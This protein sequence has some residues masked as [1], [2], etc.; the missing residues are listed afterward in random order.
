MHSCVLLTKELL[1]EVVIILLS[2]AG[3]KITHWTGEGCGIWDYGSAD[4]DRK[5][6]EEW[7][8]LEISAD[9]HRHSWQEACEGL[10]S[11]QCRSPAGVSS[12]MD[13]WK[14]EQWCEYRVTSPLHSSGLTK[15]FSKNYF[16]TMST[17]DVTWTLHI[18]IQNVTYGRLQRPLYSYNQFFLAL[19][20]STIQA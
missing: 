17:R 13:G 14:T 12:W 2:A 5:T 8:I 19:A 6:E 4:T 15:D 16:A 9:R 18:T 11:L 7:T 3:W 1:H 10:S 20:V